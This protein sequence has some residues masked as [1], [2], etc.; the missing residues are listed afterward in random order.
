VIAD[1]GHVTGVWTGGRRV[2]PGPAIR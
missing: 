1:P 2:K